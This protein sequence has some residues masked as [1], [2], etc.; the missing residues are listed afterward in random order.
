[1]VKTLCVATVMWLKYCQY[2]YQYINHLVLS[3]KAGRKI[4]LFLVVINQSVQQFETC[5]SH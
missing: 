3:E 2:Q 5:V 4:N 1:M